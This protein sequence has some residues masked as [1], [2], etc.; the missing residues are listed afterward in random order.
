MYTNFTEEYKKIMIDT[1]NAIKQG[2]ISEICPE[3]VF[4]QTL[5]IKTGPIYE[6]YASYGI[7]EKIANEVLIK[8]PF[9]RNLESRVGEYRGL[10]DRLKELIVLSVK[11][12]A[13]AEKKK[14]GT[15]DFLLALFRSN[16]ESW[17]YQ[18]FDFIG[19]SPK[20]FEQNLINLN[21]ELS[22]ESESGAVFGPLD[23]ILHA[24]EEGLAG[25]GIEEGEANNPFIGNKKPEG[26][27][28][29]STTP[30]LDFFGND[31][32]EEARLGK[33]DAIIGRDMEIER[34]ISVL[35]RKTKNNPCLVGE[36]GVGKTAVVEG[37]ALR[38]AQGKVPLAMQNKRIISLDL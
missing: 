19:V 24:L 21:T 6:L 37:L 4:L 8:S 35:N 16:T 28:D 15:S 10:S 33:I 2:G 12:A 32:T 34:L 27:K 25:G 7:N 38:I 9:N 30:A 1:E 23:N 26:K 22:K 31:L 29:E 18:F 11:I 13:G 14:A 20:D 36:P 17:C 3:D 5:K